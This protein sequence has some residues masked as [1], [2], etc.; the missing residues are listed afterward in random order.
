LSNN[1]DFAAGGE[2]DVIGQQRLVDGGTAREAVH[3]DFDVA[4]AGVL[5]TGFNH[6]VVDDHVLGQVKQ[7]ELLR[8][9]DG[10]RFGLGRGGAAGRKGQCDSAADGRGRGLA[11]KAS[12]GHGIRPP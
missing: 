3:G 1:V 7:A 11:C 10:V 4:Q 2:V 6:L 5:G 12:V 9:T 8:E